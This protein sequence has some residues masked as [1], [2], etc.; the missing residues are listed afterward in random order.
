MS[1]FLMRTVLK[2][3]V[4]YLSKIGDGI[5]SIEKEYNVKKAR[6]VIELKLVDG[7]EIPVMKFE[8]V[9]ED[10]TLKVLR[11]ERIEGLLN[12]ITG[13][14]GKNEDEDDE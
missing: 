1:N 14:K 10:F 13:D 12:L 6:I 8:G 4:P 7:K 5:K 11:V 3:V 2:Q 9:N